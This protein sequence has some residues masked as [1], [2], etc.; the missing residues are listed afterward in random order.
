MLL[1]I[2]ACWEQLYLIHIS[3]KFC[4]WNWLLAMGISAAIPEFGGRRGPP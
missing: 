4:K 2:T 3:E 1:V